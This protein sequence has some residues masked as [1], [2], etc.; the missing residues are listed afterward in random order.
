[1]AI[2]A[3][4][5]KTLQSEKLKTLTIDLILG[6]IYAFGVM[7]MI[8][9]FHKNVSISYIFILPLILGATPFLLSTKEQ[10]PSYKAYLLLP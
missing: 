10:L 4:K 3:V 1:M 8:T 2:F 7:L 9:Y 6:I 5:G